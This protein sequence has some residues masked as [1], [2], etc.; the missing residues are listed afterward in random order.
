ML[1]GHKTWVYLSFISQ[2]QINFT[3]F[4][5][6]CPE[7]KILLASG[8]QTT[9]WLSVQGCRDAKNRPQLKEH[10][11]LPPWNS[12]MILLDVFRC[13]YV[14]RV[15]GFAHVNSVQ[16]LVLKDL[17]VSMLSPRYECWVVLNMKRISFILSLRCVVPCWIKVFQGHYRTEH[18]FHLCVFTL[19]SSPILG[20]WNSHSP[21]VAPH[22]CSH[23]LLWGNLI[24]GRLFLEN[25]SQTN[26]DLPKTL[27]CNLRII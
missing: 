8:S 18:H 2:L 20:Q 4:S 6:V 3:S 12:C 23:F 17:A 21:F 24:R 13:F 19:D 11:H 7:K 9:A 26:L 22:Q 1:N 25:F 27:A 10:E 15:L 5:P 14:F 16:V